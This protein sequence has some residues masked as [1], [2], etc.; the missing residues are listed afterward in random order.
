LFDLFPILCKLF[1]LFLYYDI[2]RLLEA[3][4][5]L[6]KEIVEDR[7]AL[8]NTCGY[9]EEEIRHPIEKREEEKEAI[10]TK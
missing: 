6:R 3:H 10:Y 8:L 1:L 5:A 9:S 4:G 7:N 2:V